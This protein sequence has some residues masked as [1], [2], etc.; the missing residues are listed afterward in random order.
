MNLMNICFDS[1]PREAQNMRE[2][3]NY[4]SSALRCGCICFTDTWI[5]H[6]VPQCSTTLNVMQ[7]DAQCRWWAPRNL[8]LA[9]RNLAFD[10]EDVVIVICV[11]VFS[12][13]L[14]LHI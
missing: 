11:N 12:L 4:L 2:A 3:P 9:P 13:H 5:P 10:I 1:W 14:G 8:T 6:L 7:T